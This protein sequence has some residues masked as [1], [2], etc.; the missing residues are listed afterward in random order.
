VSPTE[1]DIEEVVDDIVGDDDDAPTESTG[2]TLVC[3][4]VGPEGVCGESFGTPQALGLHRWKEHQ[5]RGKHADKKGK[6]R[7]N[8]ASG[9]TRSTRKTTAAPKAAATKAA[10]PATDRAGT[11]TASLAMAALAAY[12]ALPPFDQFDLDVC[13]AGT[14]NIGKALA[15]LADHNASV[16]RAT[17]L[18]LGGGAGGDWIAVIMA[19]TPVVGAIAAHHGAIPATSGA[20]FGEMIGVVPVARPDVPPP[21]A[22]TG[23]PPEP[24]L[25][26]TADDVL[27]FIMTTPDTVMTDAMTKMMSMGGPIGVAV[28]DTAVTMSRTDTEPT[29][30]ERGS[31]QLRPVEPGEAAEQEPAEPVPA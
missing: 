22:P 15:Q 8:P 1:S 16:A 23:E 28:P 19:V 12:W 3:D 17:D 14:P 18:I 13:N 10:G 4:H 5:I 29:D 26:R 11:Y 24:D 7:R 25:G 6:N 31:E 27:A 21:A 2:T 9:N 30:G 20:R